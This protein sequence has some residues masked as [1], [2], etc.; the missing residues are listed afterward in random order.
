[1]VKL[2]LDSNAIPSVDINLETKSQTI[3]LKAPEIREYL[4]S[5]ILMN[6]STLFNILFN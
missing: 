1:M 4:Q 6:E 3:D 5:G 2:L